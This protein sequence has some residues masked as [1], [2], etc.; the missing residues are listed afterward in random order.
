MKGAAFRLSGSAEQIELPSDE[1]A[2]DTFVLKISNPGIT[3]WRRSKHQ[4]AMSGLK[5]PVQIV[6]QED[7]EVTIAGEPTEVHL[8]S[9]ETKTTNCN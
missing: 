6:I 1:T 9:G 2:I 8:Q 7:G 3:R 4:K 5:E